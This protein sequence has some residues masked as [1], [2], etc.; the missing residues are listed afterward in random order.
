MQLQ[1]LEKLHA[2]AVQALTALD[3]LGVTA[4][5]GPRVDQLPPLN[6]LLHGNP[7]AH[8]RENIDSEMAQ[9]CLLSLGSSLSGA[10]WNPW[11]KS[12]GRAAGGACNALYAAVEQYESE[13]EQQRTDSLFAS[14]FLSQMRPL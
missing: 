3:K 11:A 10:L 12:V 6:A 2:S 4:C 1:A 7:G 14:A 8:W 13:Q 9:A 5:V